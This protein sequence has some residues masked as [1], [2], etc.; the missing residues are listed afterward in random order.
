MRKATILD[1]KLVTEIIAN[2]FNTN[3]SVC[4]VIRKKNKNRSIRALA[5]FAFHYS[6]RRDGVYISSDKTGVALCYRYNAKKESVGDYI[7]Q[8]KLLLSA[9]N[10]R[11]VPSLLKREAFIKSKRPKNG[12]YL[13]FWMYGVT[14]EG[15]GKTAARELKNH[16]F[17]ESEEKKLPIYVETSVP[18]NKLVYERFGFVTHNEWEEAAEG[19]T[20]W[21]LKRMPSANTKTAT[22]QSQNGG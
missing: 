22:A 12:D 4:S 15:R 21:L 18:Q 5:K 17:A 6:L 1:E 7:L 11:Y 10:I 2:S 20:L 8:A 19:F 13:Y 3:P 16:I 14:N 9:L